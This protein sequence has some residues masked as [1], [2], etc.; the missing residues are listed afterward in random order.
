[1]ACLYYGVANNKWKIKLTPRLFLWENK[2][3]A[4]TFNL[5]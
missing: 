1:M 5:I 2:K 4:D 3:I